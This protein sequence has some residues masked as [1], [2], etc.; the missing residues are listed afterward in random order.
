MRR[1]D[2]SC[3]SWR[4]RLPREYFVFCRRIAEGG[5]SHVW[6][7]GRDTERDSVC[8][9]SV[10]RGSF[11]GHCCRRAAGPRTS[12]KSGEGQ[13]RYRNA[14]LLPQLAGP[15]VAA[16]GFMS[17]VIARLEPSAIGG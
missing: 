1:M 13:A 5:A 10:G 6:Q 3:C 9:L 2:G 12:N 16:P 7:A 11:D 8:A 14:H 15:Q 4:S 17:A